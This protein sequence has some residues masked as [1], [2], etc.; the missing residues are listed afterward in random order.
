M[1]AFFIA[2]SYLAR[3]TS[4]LDPRG[5]DNRGACFEE[6]HEHHQHNHSH[7]QHDNDI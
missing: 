2:F 3:I 4:G 5:L 1:H 7:G 6:G